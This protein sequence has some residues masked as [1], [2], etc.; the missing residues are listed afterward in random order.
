[1][2]HA[3]PPY[4]PMG[5]ASPPAYPY[6]PPAYPYAQQ[7]PPR[8]NPIPSVRSNPLL[9]Q[10]PDLARLDQ[11][12]RGISIAPPSYEQYCR[13]YNLRVPPTSQYPVANGGGGGQWA[14]GQ[15]RGSVQP[16]QGPYGTEAPYSQQ[17]RDH[18]S[19][20]GRDQVR[21]YQDYRPPPRDVTRT[22]ASRSAHTLFGPMPPI[23]WGNLKQFPPTLI[24]VTP[25]SI[26]QDI[27]P[28]WQRGVL[29]FQTTTGLSPLSQGFLI[30]EAITKA[31]KAHPG[32]K[33]AVNAVNQVWADRMSALA[34]DASGVGLFA[35]VNELVNRVRQTLEPSYHI[36][37]TATRDR[38]KGLSGYTERRNWTTNPLAQIASI[39]AL[40][41]QAEQLDIDINS[42]E[43]FTDLMKSLPSKVTGLI[44]AQQELR[45]SLRTAPELIRWVREVSNESG[46]HFID[47][48]TGGGVVNRH[49]SDRPSEHRSS[50]GRSHHLPMALAL[51]TPPRIP[52]KGPHRP[53]GAERH[54]QDRPGADRRGRDADRAGSSGRGRSNSYT[55]NRDPLCT[56][57]GAPWTEGHKA[58]CAGRLCGTCPHCGGTG[59]ISRLCWKQHP[60]LRAQS[61]AG[62][63][64][65]E[66]ERKRSAS[67]AA[68]AED[69]RSSAPERLDPQDEPSD[70]SPQGSEDSAG[71]ALFGS[72]SDESPSAASP[73]GSASSGSSSSL[74]P[75]R[76]RRT[77]APPPSATPTLRPSRAQGCRAAAAPHR[78]QDSR[79][80]SPPKRVL[81]QPGPRRAQGTSTRTNPPTMDSRPPPRTA[82]HQQGRTRTA[83]RAGTR[84]GRP[85]SHI[86][87]TPKREPTPA[88]LRLTETPAWPTQ[89]RGPWRAEPGQLHAAAPRSGC[90]RSRG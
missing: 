86:S 48:F 11:E 35:L 60:H 68:F 55:S 17:Q 24:E 22:D 4:P 15:Q 18:A 31:V 12:Q 29:H 79:S 5:H 85:D 64:Q 54:R 37:Q 57:C 82:Q 69:R 50:W 51:T 63:R 2:G 30:I 90:S 14:A 78:R 7:Q 25:E 62:Q 46:D 87:S 32:C 72:G 44:V 27:K 65:L 36:Q 3:S 47:L 84:T 73:S 33:T 8:N 59:H 21:A 89:L 81:G 52:P 40:F 74:R 10:F 41:S 1:M 76:A 9:A 70:R 42:Y 75:R 80:R 13:E 34:S 6:A 26:W 88:G 83:A 28:D 61:P 67:P 20:A 58:E 71:Y 45:Q 19:A 23:P 43:V 49:R 53:Q 39:E 77:P 56:G 16:S 66:R 38:I